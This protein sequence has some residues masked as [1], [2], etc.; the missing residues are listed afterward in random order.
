MSTSRIVELS[1]RIAANTAALD[2]Y[3]TSKNLP[4]PS[5]DID[6]PHDCLVPKSEVDIEKARIAIAEDTTEL[7]SLVLGP[8]E[9]LMS[10]SHNDLLS[11]QATVRFRL[12]QSFPVGTETT[13]SSIA[14]F[15]GLR[16][17]NV[18]QI[19]RHAIMMNVFCEPRPGVIAHNAVSRLLAE[20]KPIFDWLATN[21]N[22]LWKAAAHTC[23]AWEKYPESDEPNQTGFSLA[24]QT[25]KSI[26]EVFSQNPDRAKSFGN[27]MR[28]FTQGT[29]FE[30]RH[31]VDN[32]HWASFKDGTVVDV[33]GSQGHV[34]FAVA[35]AFPSLSFVVQD[36]E[37]VITTAA[38]E[39]PRDVAA[40]VKFM[41]HDFLTEQPVHNAD[42]YIFRWIF[43][44]WSD[45]NCIRILRNLIPALKPGA[46]IIVNDNVLPQPGSISKWQ[47]KK[48]RDMDLA[49]AEIQ[50]SRE[51]ELGDWRSLFKLADDRGVTGIV[52]T[53]DMTD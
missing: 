30:L 11:L 43:H 13:F 45:K 29:G 17:S 26:F 2:A 44:N 51:R 50:N 38:K 40:R 31:V 52:E 49:M 15:C 9:Y 33:G 16:E 47:E 8:R 6:G 10:C 21:C 36:L 1:A 19:L 28:S 4:T 14:A 22:E 46:K 7:R 48:L 41:A 12:T 42:V 20:E 53:T 3:L 24:N 25:D 34:C 37:S 18:R 39:I 23:E 32:I 27:A 5:F 35:R